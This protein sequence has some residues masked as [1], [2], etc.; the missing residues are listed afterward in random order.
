MLTSVWLCL[1]AAGLSIP[2]LPNSSN[3]LFFGLCSARRSSLLVYMELEENK[4]VTP[5]LAGPKC[6]WFDSA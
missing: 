4:R 5:S 6:A 2:S 3:G 1:I